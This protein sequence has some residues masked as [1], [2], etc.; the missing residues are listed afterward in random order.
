MNGLDY[1]LHPPF[2]HIYLEDRAADCPTAVKIMERFPGAAIVRIKHYKEIFNRPRQNW[3]EQKE[4]QKLI[5]AKRQDHFFYEGSDKTAACGFEHHYYN[6]LMLNCLYDCDYC[7]LQ[8]LYPGANMVIFVNNEDYLIQTGELLAACQ[9]L[10]LCISYD[11]DLLAFEKLHNYCREWIAFAAKHPQLF[12]EIRTKSANYNL[13]QDL[14]PAPNVV[15]AWTVSPPELAKQYE[16]RAPS[17]RARLQSAREAQQDGW[18][19]RL[20]LDP[21]LRV[22]FWQKVYPA[23]LDELFEYVSADKLKDFQIGAFRMNRRYLKKIQQARVEPAV[24][25]H[26]FS[27]AGSRS[28]Y[29]AQEITELQDTLNPL[30]LR[31]LTRQQIIWT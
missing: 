10:Y 19:V 11:T 21:V 16:K 18:N 6:S 31:R 12:I 20:C 2:S 30:L 4:S 8:G 7:Y 9:P 14:S 29:S 17:V 5:L 13:I 22:P 28:G 23:F 15:L 26:P 3:C 27:H 24:L 1:R 25:F